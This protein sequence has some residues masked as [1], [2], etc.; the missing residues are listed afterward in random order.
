MLKL[1]IIFF[2]TLAANAGCLKEVTVAVIDTGIDYNHTEL[3]GAIKHNPLEVVNKKDDD[4]NGFIDDYMGWDFDLDD[5]FPYDFHGHGTH[6]A[7]LI[8]NRNEC[9]KILPLKYYNSSGSGYKN[10][11]NTVRSINYAIDYKVDIINYSSGGPEPSRIERKA[12]EKAK[13]AGILFIT[14]AGNFGWDLKTRPYYPASYPLDNIISVSALN[15]QGKLLPHSN[16]N[17]NVSA[18][19]LNVKSTLPGNKEGTMSGTSQSAAIVSGY[20]AKVLSY[21]PEYNYLQL[22]REVLN[23]FNN[24][25]R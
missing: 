23:F 20:A 11:K 10:L 21:H 1:F 25:E 24:A 12:I 16:Y 14:A 18:L 3:A 13:K 22:K 17:A 19:G 7:G 2:L 6:I 5:N 8:H 9:V 15:R 4:K